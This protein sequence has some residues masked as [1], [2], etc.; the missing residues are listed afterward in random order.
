M[1][2]Y[3]DSFPEDAGLVTPSL[4]K[5]KR[6]STIPDHYTS[7]TQLYNATIDYDLDFARLTSSSS[8]GY[9]DGLFEVDLSGTFGLAIPFYLFDHGVW[10]TF[11]QETRLV[12]DSGGPFDWT[13]G[14][15]YLHRDSFLEGRQTSTP[16]FLAA[17]GLPTRPSTSSQATPPPMSWPAS[18]SSPGTSPA[19][20]RSPAGCATANMVPRSR[21]CRGSTRSISPM[22]WPA[23]RDGSNRRPP[24]PERPITPRRPG[25]R[26]RRASAIAPRATFRPMSPCRPAI[27]RRCTMRA[28][29]CRARSIRPIW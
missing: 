7:K 6:Y 22:R 3:E 11:V 13:I 9:Q 5:R 10:K 25:R 20:S 29:A 23:L 21:R 15:Y 17:R 2:L 1:A 4:G 27:A 19:R 26:G 12:S 24:R 16:E 28:P 14:G 8:Y 18:A